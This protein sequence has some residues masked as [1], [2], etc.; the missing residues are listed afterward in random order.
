MIVPDGQRIAELRRLGMSESLVRLASGECIHEIFRYT[1]LGP[2]HYVYHLARTPDGPLIGLLD[3]NDT[4]IG[5]WEQPDGPEFIKFS[6]EAVNEF[7]KLARTEQGFWADQFDFFYECDVLIKELQEAAAVVGF[8]FL[9]RYLASRK[10]AESRL[11][12]FEA[13]QVWLQQ[14]VAGVDR[15]STP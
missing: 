3:C 15:E 2:P 6:V 1:A 10:G 11:H 14:L 7:T 5:L 13:H 9:D 8:R 12:T 4:V